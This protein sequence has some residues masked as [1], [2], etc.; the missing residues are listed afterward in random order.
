MSETGDAS[1]GHVIHPEQ[2]DVYFDSGGVRLA[3]TLLMPPGH[4][5]HPAVVILQGSGTQ[6]RRYFGPLPE[7]F[8]RDGLA[9]LCFDKPGVG[10][11]TGNWRH[12]TLRDR[13]RQALDAI[14]T[15]RIGLW[16]HS[17]GGWVVPLAAA[18]APEVA[19]IVAVACPGITPAEQDVYGVEHRMRGDG[20][21]PAAIAAATAY[22]RAIIEAARRDREYADVKD[23]VL[24]GARGEAWYHYFPVPD[25]DTWRFF[26]TGYQQP[27]D[28]AT[29]LRRV[30]CPVP[31]IF[32]E[33]DSLLPVDR[34]V[35]IFGAAL[36]EAGNRDV[37]IAVFLGA[38]RGLAWSRRVGTPQATST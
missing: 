32:G 13:A 31:T 1:A 7:R 24:R 33:R 34:S 5:P 14:R 6:D 4:G 2:L 22:V 38:D 15:D 30:T 18:S 21:A 26:R 25:A 19:F 36:R 27:Y 37:T 3:G 8:A 17:Q 9:V 23:A 20:Y 28:P 12:Q 16:G 11:S 10:A 35:G 29:A